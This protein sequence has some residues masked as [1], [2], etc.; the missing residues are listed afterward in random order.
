MKHLYILCVLLL[1]VVSCERG[2]DVIGKLGSR[3]VADVPEIES[4]ISPSD[5]L[6]SP[7]L[8][9]TWGLHCVVDSVA[10]FQLR[11]ATGYCF[12]A[13]D[14]K[15]QTCR[16]FLSVGR[17]PNEVIAGFFSNIRHEENRTLLDITAINE[18]LLLSID[19]EET[20]R[21]GQTT[22]VS[23]K[24][25]MP[26]STNSF[27]VGDRILSEV[28]NDIDIYSYKLYD[29]VSQDVSWMVQPFG[30]EEYVALYQPLFSATLKLKPDG[31]KLSVSMLFFDGINI[32]DVGGDDHIGMSVSKQNKDASTIRDALSGRQMG[33][34]YYY[35]EHDVT[36]EGIFALYYNTKRSESKLREAATI[37]VFS[38][39][40]KLEAV[41]HMSE[42]LI[43]I[44]VSKDGN[45][46]YGVTAEEILY[47]YDLN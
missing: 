9:A 5:S 23:T 31:S 3:I 1:F 20:L 2:Q 42:P 27:L 34:R 6:C 11:D 47:V 43:S 21:T 25:L 10:I 7:L 4:E 39:T 13:L 45:T 37:H 29:A 40:G 26:Q 19:L 14:F 12:R 35:M 41:Y 36:D 18:G 28:V 38:W 32:F 17:G 22:I 8:D 24:E 33:D 16:D 30:D 46:L 15:T 44:A